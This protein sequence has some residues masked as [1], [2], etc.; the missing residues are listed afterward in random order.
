MK[1]LIFADGEIEEVIEGAEKDA[2][3]KYNELFEENK[4]TYLFKKLELV[5]C[6]TLNSS[7]FEDARYEETIKEK[8][9]LTSNMEIK[10]KSD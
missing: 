9:E 2:Q 10:A 5:E 3:E 7:E 4:E 1:Y 6:K 8:K